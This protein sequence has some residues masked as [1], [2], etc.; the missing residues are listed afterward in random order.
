MLKTESMQVIYVGGDSRKHWEGRK[1]GEVRQ[2]R[3]RSQ[4]N[5]CLLSTLLF[6]ST[7]ERWKIMEHTWN[8]L[9]E[10]V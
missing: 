2:G 7:E 3:E 6:H 10:E 9:T 5:M 1:Y 4:K 8:Y